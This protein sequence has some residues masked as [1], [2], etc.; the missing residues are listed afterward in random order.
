MVLDYLSFIL[1][2]YVLSR[3]ED[4][5]LNI[6]IEKCLLF[7]FFNEIYGLPNLKIFHLV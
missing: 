6:V 3:S 2:C 4:S 1:F 5:K 7:F